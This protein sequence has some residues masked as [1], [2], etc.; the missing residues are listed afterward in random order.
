MGPLRQHH[1]QNECIADVELPEWSSIQLSSSLKQRLHSAKFA[2]PTDI[3]RQ[4][5]PHG[6]SGRDVIGVA[7]TARRST[8]G[9]ATL[10]AHSFDFVVG[11][12]KDASIWPSDHPQHPRG[13]RK[14]RFQRAAYHQSTSAHT[15]SRVGSAGCRA[16]GCYFAA[17]SYWRQ[18]RQTSTSSQRSCDRRRDERTETAP[19]FGPGGRHTHRHARP[20]MGSDTGGEWDV[21][22]REHVNRVD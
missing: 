1:T 15:Y 13:I 16:L 10:C 19:R 6:L 17:C 12:R 11:F 14:C 22:F 4:A 9:N 3:Q 8:R 20:I 18:W 2:V 21:V 5:L 7:E